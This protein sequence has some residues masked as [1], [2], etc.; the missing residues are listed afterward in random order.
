[1][2]LRVRVTLW[3]YSFPQY[4]IWQKTILF[5]SGGMALTSDSSI[6]ISEVHLGSLFIYFF[7][8]FYFFATLAFHHPP[9]QICLIFA[10]SSFWS[11]LNV[12]FSLSTDYKRS[13]SD[14]ADSQEMSFCLF[15]KQRGTSERNDLALGSVT[16]NRYQKISSKS[17][18]MCLWLRSIQ[19]PLFLQQIVKGLNS[20]TRKSF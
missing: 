11:D 9:M 1:M 2:E 14:G 3:Q 15:T 7:V 20:Q 12:P 18:F 16:L 10:R 17:R 6:I 19:L 5:F 8:Y 13:K 4:S